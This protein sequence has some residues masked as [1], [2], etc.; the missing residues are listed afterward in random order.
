M[1][2]MQQLLQAAEVKT[3]M[4]GRWQALDTIFHRKGKL[5]L[6]LLLGSDNPQ[7]PIFGL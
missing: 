1:Q 3:S 2:E 7:E 4:E 6:S 5:F